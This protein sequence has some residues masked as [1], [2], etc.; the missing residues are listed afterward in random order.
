MAENFL[1][2]EGRGVFVSLFKATTPKQNPQ[3]A[4][5][6]TLRIAFPPSADLSE[7]KRQAGIAASEKWGDKVPKVLRSPFRTNDE[8]EN[9]IDGIGDDWTV[10]TFTANAD[11]RPGLVDGN[12]NDIIDE[13]DVYS[14][15]WFRAQVRAYAYE[16]AGNKGVSF[17]LQNVQKLR[18]DEPMGGGRPKASSAFTKVE[19]AGEGKD[20]G[21]IFG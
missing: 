1:T 20:A 10:M 7:M 8:L 5:K 6:Y 4:P 15:A 14:G 9:P 2:P 12:L 3:A 13:A 11:R 21:S 17:G 19:G 18:D 16:N